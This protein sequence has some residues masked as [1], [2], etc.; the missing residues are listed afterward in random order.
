M[1]VQCFRAGRMYEALEACDQAAARA[2]LRAQQAV[3]PQS[4]RSGCYFRPTFQPAAKLRQPI[5]SSL[6]L[7]RA[8]CLCFELCS[9]KLAQQDRLLH[10]TLLGL[11]LLAKIDQRA[12][13][14]V[15]RL[16]VCAA[17]PSNI[18]GRFPTWHGLFEQPRFGKMMREQLGNTCDLFGKTLLE[19]GGN[20][21]MQ[22]L[23]P[24]PQQARIC[25]IFDQRMLEGIE[26][27]RRSAAFEDELGLDELC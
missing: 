19:R 21:R 5:E 24:R 10:V 11:R 16:P 13:Q 14:M 2:V 27:I 12:V 17:L 3:P 20:L 26:G 18:G 6:L 9:P 22:E 7:G 4:H 8:I 23:A 15:D 1:A 25:R